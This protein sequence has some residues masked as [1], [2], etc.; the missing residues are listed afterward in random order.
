MVAGAV[1]GAF[2]ARISGLIKV[3][4][5]T[6]PTISRGD[7]NIFIA[8]KLSSTAFIGETQSFAHILMS[9]GGII[10]APFLP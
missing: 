6:M 10:P 3:N 2:C 7:V 8:V 1:R 4:K 9:F 5:L